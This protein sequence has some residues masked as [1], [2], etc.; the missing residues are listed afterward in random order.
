MPT[1]SNLVKKKKIITQKYQRL[2]RKLLIMIM[3][4][5]LPPAEHFSARLAQ[6]NLVTKTD[7][8]TRLRS[9]NKINLKALIQ[10]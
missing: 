9:L 3:I 6:V 1:I 10:T 8:D 5:I 2:K 7:F 4:N